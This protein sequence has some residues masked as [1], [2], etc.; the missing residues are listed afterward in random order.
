MSRL[1]EEQD[2]KDS[3]ISMAPKSS[4]TEHRHS[5]QQPI[6]QSLHEQGEKVV[7]QEFYHIM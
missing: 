2:T 1:D 4:C 5:K 7:V 3:K 6:S